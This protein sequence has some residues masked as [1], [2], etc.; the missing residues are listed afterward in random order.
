[1]Q[2]IAALQQLLTMTHTLHEQ[3]G[4]LRK[5]QQET[6]TLLNQIIDRCQQAGMAAGDNQ[7]SFTAMKEKLF[8]IY[9]DSDKGS[10]TSGG[11]GEKLDSKDA[12]YNSSQDSSDGFGSGHHFGRRNMQ[13]G[14]SSQEYSSPPTLMEFSKRNS[15]ARGSNSSMYI[16]RQ[17]P[18]KGSTVG[19]GGRGFADSKAFSSEGAG[20]SH[21][22]Y[23]S[24][25]RNSDFFSAGSRNI[26]HHLMAETPAPLMDSCIELAMEAASEAGTSMASH[27]GGL[28]NF[29]SRSSAD[30]VLT[31]GG[32]APSADTKSSNTSS[33]RGSIAAGLKLPGGARRGS[34][35]RGVQQ[36][37]SSQDMGINK[38]ESMSIMETKEEDSGK[39]NKGDGDESQEYT[40]ES[41]KYPRA[42]N[43][44]STGTTRRPSLAI[45]ARELSTKHS[46]SDNKNHGQSGANN[47]QSH[48]HQHQIHT[49]SAND[50]PQPSY[51]THRFIL[52]E[53]NPP[54]PPVLIQVDPGSTDLIA[55]SQTGA[56]S[57]TIGLQKP[58]IIKKEKKRSASFKKGKPRTSLHMVTNADSLSSDEGNDDEHDDTESPEVSAGSLPR[59][60]EESENVSPGGSAS[61]EEGMIVSASLKSEDGS[62]MSTNPSHLT[63]VPPLTLLPRRSLPETTL[64]NRRQL[65]EGVTGV[66]VPPMPERFAKGQGEYT[67]GGAKGPTEYT[68]GGTVTLTADSATESTQQPQQHQQPQAS[69][70]S[71]TIGS[72]TASTGI[73]ACS[74][75]P[76]VLSSQLASRTASR[77]KNPGVATPKQSAAVLPNLPPIGKASHASLPGQSQMSIAMSAD[78]NEPDSLWTILKIKFLE[79]ALDGVYTASYDQW[80]DNFR[81]TVERTIHIEHVVTSRIK[82]MYVFVIVM[83]PFAMS[84]E[85]FEW[86]DEVSYVIYFI[87]LLDTMLQFLILK[88]RDD[89]EPLA[90]HTLWNSMKQYMAGPLIFDL[91]GSVPIYPIIKHTTTWSL[92]YVTMAF[93]LIHTRRLVAIY[94]KNPYYR[95]LSG[96]IRRRLAVGTSFMSIFVFAGLLSLFLHYHACLIFFSGRV[97]DYSSA[98]WTTGG[99]S[100]SLA[101]LDLEGA[102]S[103]AAKDID[104]LKEPLIAQYSWALLASMANTFP[105]TGY[106]PKDPPEQFITIVS[107]LIG[108]VLYAALVGTISSFSLGLD[109]SGRKFREKLDEVNEFMEYRKLPEYIKTKELAIHQVRDLISK[110]PFLCRQMN[111]GRDEEFLSKVALALHPQYYIPGDAIFRQGEIGREMYFICTGVVEIIVKNQV[112]GAMG[113]GT[114]FGE[115]ALMSNNPRSA[116]IRARSYTTVY[117]LS[118][119]D[120]QYILEEFEDVAFLMNQVYQQRMQKIQLE[121]KK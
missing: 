102:D 74:D 55:G 111:D 101:I 109:S 107:I 113:A 105:V 86:A 28:S 27:M 22:H 88:I 31:M 20:G 32:F 40:S 106:L 18:S 9:S 104:R 10:V 34:L 89:G 7:A 44:S 85:A 84:F 77:I 112:V 96:V 76:P 118:M 49:S 8:T 51:T 115:V 73:L 46:A 13:T 21:D 24:G 110:V 69:H 114:F 72:V 50:I 57:G 81:G 26:P 38:M 63:P 64:A 41:R 43:S 52:E 80:A 119:D 42:T 58:I 82:A 75:E 4:A 97:T 116:T 3:E 25:N 12:F 62:I 48:T 87:H 90:T 100:T 33:R 71:I 99:G 14:N 108:A 53:L 103:N 19:G 16:V 79:M 23:T 17:K 1:M 92:S 61:H 30:I 65:P 94:R 29:G 11:H 67:S 70:K 68:S 117:C 93:T 98:T 120:F 47:N 45:S 78:A 66:K 35:L 36:F 37:I 56:G 59:Q 6:M 60:D 95:L 5:L 39:K 83:V 2:D 121:Q 91:V 54:P 15:S